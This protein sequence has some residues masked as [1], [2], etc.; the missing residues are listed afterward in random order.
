MNL[1]NFY[2]V[3]NQILKIL[4]IK[5]IFAKN[6]LDSSNVFVKI[7]NSYLKRV[8]CASCLMFG[9]HKGHN[10]LSFEDAVQMM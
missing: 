4:A 3:I 6:I 9:N 2:I 1:L 8:I 7:V 10:V 5:I